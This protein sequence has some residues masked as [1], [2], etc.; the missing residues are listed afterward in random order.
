MLSQLDQLAAQKEAAEAEL[1]QEREALAAAVAGA[2]AE[3]RSIA[4][5]LSP[6]M[7]FVTG[8]EL[9]RTR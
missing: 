5:Q 4:T 1:A 8:V 6:A 9:S 2:P 3:S 7:E